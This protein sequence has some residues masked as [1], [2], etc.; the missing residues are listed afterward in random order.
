MSME[1]GI[2][3]N[4][5]IS[6]NGDWISVYRSIRTHPVIGFLN[7]DGTRRKN[8]K[9]C[10]S[11]AWIDL[12]M[13][14]N[15]R[16]RQENNNGQPIL[17]ERGQLQG[18]R[19]WLAERWGW[20]DEQ[21]RWFLKKLQ[22]DDMILVERPKITR[23]SH[24][25]HTPSTPKQTAKSTRFANVIT[26]RNY[27][28][29]QTISELNELIPTQT[30]PQTNP[31]ITPIQP[32]HSNK[33]IINNKTTLQRERARPSIDELQDK[34]LDACNGAAANPAASPGI[35]IMSEP[36]KWIESGCDLELDI[37]P[38]IRA[39]SHRLRPGSVK[40]WSYFTQAV[41]DAKASRET[42]MPKGEAKPKR[43]SFLEAQE[44]ERRE[45]IYRGVL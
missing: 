3:D 7:S 2:G 14:A 15:W 31:Q 6:A 42:P 26:I 13:E 34:L 9:V 10:P 8:A 27:N 22:D 40:N 28:T 36:I 11:M 5:I 35:L 33:E 44:A 45:R 21:V 24:R 19:K 43:M 38:T 12:C 20:T 25:N 18:A 23:E 32:P 29:Y 30:N 4:S 16:D 1:R 41:A 17:V 39:R 37:L